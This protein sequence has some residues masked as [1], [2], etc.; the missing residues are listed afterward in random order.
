MQQLNRRFYTFFVPGL[1]N[2]VKL[3]EI[4][5]MGCGVI[6]FPGQEAYVNVLDFTKSYLW[7]FVPV[8]FFDMAQTFI[9]DLQDLYKREEALVKR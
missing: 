7:D 4:G 5:N 2:S 3:F 8:S 1:V 6:V 9:F